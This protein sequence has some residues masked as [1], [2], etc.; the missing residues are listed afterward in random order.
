MTAGD[1]ALVLTAAAAWY[2]AGLI[3]FVQRT[4]YPMMRWGPQDRFAD[5]EQEH[6]QRTGPVT[7]PPM[8]V[9]LASA[10]WLVAAIPQGVP[11]WTA[12]LSLAL[13]V[14]VFAHTL[15]VFVPL[16]RKLGH[17]KDEAALRKLVAHN[18]LRTTLWSARALL[19]AGMIL[20][21]LAV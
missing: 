13:A 17:G 16:H 18:W 8:L 15:A 12:W 20:A 19:L 7:G 9:E 10:A 4:H 2:M 5:F 14:A 1:A 21:R 3:W 6:M 11:A